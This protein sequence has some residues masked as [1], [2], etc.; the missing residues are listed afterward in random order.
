VSVDRATLILETIQKK[1]V[2]L[3]WEVLRQ[4]KG[5]AVAGPWVEPKTSPFCE[6]AYEFVDNPTNARFSPEGE[7]VAVVW[8]DQVWYYWTTNGTQQTAPS[9]KEAL[10]KAEMEL[11]LH[12][13]LLV[14]NDDDGV[15]AD[16]KASPWESNTSGNTLAWER[17]TKASGVS[18]AQVKKSTKQNV[19]TYQIWDGDHTGAAGTSIRARMDVDQYLK[20]RGWDLE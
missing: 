19:W 10:A 2:T 4:A 11:L 3:L 9:Q 8:Q 1:S 14:G 15:Y 20:D 12:R 5:L 6:A 17:R 7:C 13:W 18:V 16:K